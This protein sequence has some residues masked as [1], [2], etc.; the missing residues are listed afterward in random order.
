MVDY[1]DL[2]LKTDVLFLA[3]VFEKFISACLQYYGLDSCHYLSSTELAWDVMLKM[4]QIKLD[5]ILDIGMQNLLK[6]E[7]KEVFFTLLKHSVK[8]II[9]TRNH[10]MLINQANLLRI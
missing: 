6:N 8:Q 2:Y 10:M 5:L 3:Y 1:H 9:N 7:W 4:T